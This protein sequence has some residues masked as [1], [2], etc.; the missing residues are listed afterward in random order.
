M[1]FYI[2]WRDNILRLWD[3][4]SNTVS[5]SCGCSK[6]FTIVVKLKGR[7]HRLLLL[8][9]QLRFIIQRDNECVLYMQAEQ[10]TFSGSCNCLWLYKKQVVSQMNERNEIWQWSC[11]DWNPFIATPEGRRKEARHYKWNGQ[12]QSSKQV[13][14]CLTCGVLEVYKKSEACASFRV[15]FIGHASRICWDGVCNICRFQT[16]R[17]SIKGVISALLLLLHLLLHSRTEWTSVLMWQVR[18]TGT[19]TSS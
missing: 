12:P 14:M 15:Q 2:L 16:A 17:I 19:V 1:P 7:T 6:P 18:K 9:S 11:V 4:I 3:D 13:W 8:M 10:L 5:C